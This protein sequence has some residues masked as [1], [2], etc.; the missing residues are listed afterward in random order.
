MNNLN[1]K[2][3]IQFFSKG[4]QVS[5]AS[6]FSTAPLTRKELQVLIS[7]ALIVERKLGDVEEARKP[8]LKAVS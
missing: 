2:I 8:K 4:A 5:I 3:N 6:G 7:D 1:K